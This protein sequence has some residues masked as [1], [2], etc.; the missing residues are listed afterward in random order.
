MLE[1]KHQACSDAEAKRRWDAIVEPGHQ[2]TEAAFSRFRSVSRA[3]R[4]VLNCAVPLGR[5]R[6][7][8]DFTMPAGW[9]VDKCLVT[10]GLGSFPP[11]LAEWS[12]APQNQA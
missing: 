1:P 8:T 3:S 4:R 11:G 9:S 12:Y 6:Q 7:L 10:S 5:V 2:T